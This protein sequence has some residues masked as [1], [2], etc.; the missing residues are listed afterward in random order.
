ME[1]K[2]SSNLEKPAEAPRVE[3]PTPKSAAEKSPAL[4]FKAKGVAPVVIGFP[5]RTV[6]FTSVAFVKITED[7]SKYPA[8]VKR[9]DKLVRA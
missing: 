6:T 1:P 4:A 7:E 8:F 2:S 9:L 3:R 5:N